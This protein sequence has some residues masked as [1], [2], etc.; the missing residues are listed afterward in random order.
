[1]SFEENVKAA[2]KKYGMLDSVNTVYVGLSG[3]ADS[4]SL[5]LALIGLS[6]EYGFR[7]EAIHINHHI[8]GDESDR[9]QHFC[10]E[11]CGRLNVPLKV[12]HINA[13]AYAKEHGLSLEEGAREQRYRIFGEIGENCKVATAHTL[14]DS[15]ETVIF[16]LSRGTGIKGLA[17][18]PPVR[19]KIIRPLIYCTRREV[20]EYL[21]NMGQDFVT[22]ST[23]LSDDYTRNKIR[24]RIIPLMEE[25]HG[26]FASNIRRMTENLSSDCDCL[27]QLALSAENDDLRT[28]HSA[29]RRRV[30]INTLRKNQIE[31]N[32][33]R[34]DSLEQLVLNG[35]GKID[36][37]GD[38]YARSKNGKI[39]I[40]RIP[41]ER[42]IFEDTPVHIGRNPFL[43]ENTVI[44]EEN[45]CE[46][47]G[48]DNIIN[49]SFTNASLDCDKIQGDVILRNR[50]NGDEYIRVNRSFTS[51][52]KK[53]MNE[54][55][56]ISERDL[57][58]V[59]ADSM[60]IIWVGGFG[61]AD[62][63]KIDEN[64]TKIWNI[65]IDK[66]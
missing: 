28:L 50:R 2:V 31:V 45:N 3:G 63:V 24:H 13:E 42:V 53:L 17:G 29:V 40:S 44:I 37:S 11:L 34:I 15:A 57:I 64:T 46:N 1:M 27:E 20:E 21:G 60:G 14:N 66:K 51:S 6:G 55:Y 61:I 39:I 10:E 22:D 41:S 43:C 33:E 47:G 18:I 56:D 36:L 16:N 35:G 23:N 62:R 54:K 65:R 8:R 32:G 9:D 26:G 4:V 19:D 49:N 38:I 48:S 12:C 52:L 7:T 59:L 5:L 30:I 25:L 58:P